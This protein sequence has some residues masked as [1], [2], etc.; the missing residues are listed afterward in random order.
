[1]N[2]M[3]DDFTMRAQ[4]AGRGDVDFSISARDFETVKASGGSVGEGTIRLHPSVGGCR[5]SSPGLWGL[6]EREHT[7]KEPQYVARLDPPV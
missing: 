1:M 5:I 3:N 4:M 7:W 2:P 6:G